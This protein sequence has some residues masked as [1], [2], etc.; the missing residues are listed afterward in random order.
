[1]VDAFGH[2]NVLGN[3]K[4]DLGVRMQVLPMCEIVKPVPPTT[5]L[6]WLVPL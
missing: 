1:M 5:P 4:V 2:S 3:V 6:T